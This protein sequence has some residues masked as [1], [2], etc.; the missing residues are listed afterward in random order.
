MKCVN[1]SPSNAAARRPLLTSAK[2]KFETNIGVQNKMGLLTRAVAAAVGGVAM[3][4]P[5]GQA[6]GA[7]CIAFAVR[8]PDPLE[9]AIAVAIAPAGALF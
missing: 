9:V 2:L 1:V 7:A 4:V 5:G 6:V 8:P 3:V